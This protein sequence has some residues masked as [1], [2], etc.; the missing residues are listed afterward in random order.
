MKVGVYGLGRF[1]SFWADSLSNNLSV[2]GYSRNPTRQTGPKV[3]RVEEDELLECDVIFLC[4][5]ISAMEVVLRRIAP[6]LRSGTLVFDT[7]SVKVFPIKLMETI[8]PANV[9]IIGTHPMFGPD[10]GKEGLTGLPLVMCK[11]RAAEDIVQ[12][13][14]RKFEDLGLVVHDRTPEEHD[15]EA[16]YTQGVTHYMGRVLGELDLHASGLATLGYKKVL[17]IVEQTCND[18]Y[19]L[20]V[21]LQRYNPYTEEMRERLRSSLNKV[22]SI[23]DRAETNGDK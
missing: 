23:L 16:A 13:W 22:Q 14:R 19:Q 11:V 1:G 4:V 6:R 21:D 3:Q 17:E 8:L 20:F 15:H 5:A 7:C 18:P 12:D 9:K 10:S 2:M